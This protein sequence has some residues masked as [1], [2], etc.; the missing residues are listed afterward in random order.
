MAYVRTRFVEPMLPLQTAKLPEG[1]HWLYELGFKA[2]V[3]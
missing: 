1:A 2:T 3:P